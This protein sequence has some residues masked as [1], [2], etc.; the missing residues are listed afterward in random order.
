[1]KSK[2]KTSGMSSLAEAISK[3]W[4]A[5][6]SPGNQKRVDDDAK[7]HAEQEGA[8][9][10]AAR[11]KKLILWGVPKIAASVIVYGRVDATSSVTAVRDRPTATLLVLAGN[12]GCGKTV[13]ACTR[14][15]DRETGAL[16][17]AADFV[18][19]GNGY[20]DRDRLAALGRVGV[21]V[22]DDLGVEYHDAKMVC[23][24]DGL[25][26]SRAANGLPTI[27]TTNLTSAQFQRRYEDRIWS[28]IVQF[29]DYVE[30]DDPDLRVTP[31]GTKVRA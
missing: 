23:R 18:E 30:L 3:A 1:M 25:L 11:L 16:M 31:I 5:W 12:P 26:D 9:A 24:I 13:A 29:G 7:T 21:L 10:R 28:R 20:A 2:N 17:R 4:D 22:L 14:I 19:L 15:E 27:I 6:E 8:K